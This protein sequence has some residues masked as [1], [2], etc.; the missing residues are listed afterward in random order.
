M[1]ATLETTTKLIKPLE[2]AIVR[3]Y[4][5]GE[6]ITAGWLVSMAS[7]GKL[8]GSECDDFTEAM[9]VGVALASAATNARVDVVVF[10]PVLCM[11]GATVG[12]LIYASDT[13]GTVAETVGTKDILVGFAETATILFFRP[14]FIDFS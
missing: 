13:A 2:G 7:T 11:S 4:T 5:A 6:S 12:A 3:R 8:V 10:G 1:G 9:P 14:Q